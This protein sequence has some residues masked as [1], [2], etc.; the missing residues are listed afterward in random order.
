ME[1]KLA[2]NFL[3]ERGEVITEFI[4]NDCFVKIA[5]E[6]SSHCS[7]LKFHKTKFKASSQ[8]LCRFLQKSILHFIKCDLNVFGIEFMIRIDVD[9]KLRTLWSVHGPYLNEICAIYLKSNLFQ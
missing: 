8:Q 9:V 3:F 1:K 4:G 5:L 2:I 7:I 6:N